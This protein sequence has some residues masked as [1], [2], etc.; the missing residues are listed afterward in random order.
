M[1][2]CNFCNC[3]RTCASVLGSTLP[4]LVFVSA[5]LSALALSGG[6]GWRLEILEGVAAGLCCCGVPTTEIVP[7]THDMSS[8]VQTFFGFGL[9]AAPSA[10]GVES[11][12]GLCASANP[13]PQNN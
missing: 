7:V 12:L 4:S 8:F 1:P 13:T 6:D 3:C 9:A 5:A 10:A 2:A 11:A